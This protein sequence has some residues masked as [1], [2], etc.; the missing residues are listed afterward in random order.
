MFISLLVFILTL[1]VLFFSSRSLI[2]QLT[3]FFNRLFKSS[4]TTIN[5]IFFLLLP[6]IF[7]H[8]FS[9]VLMATLLRVQTGHISL[10]PRFKTPRASSE[11]S[12]LQLGSAQI[13]ACDPIRLTLIG[14][15]PFITGTIVLW[16]ILSLGLN[17]NLN[18]F[19]LLPLTQLPAYLLFLFSYLIFAITNTM[20][21]SPS[22]LQAAA[23]PII[24]LLIIS[25]IF[26][27]TNLDLPQII[28]TYSSSL[29]SLL[30]TI[31]LAV[32]I[33]NLLILIPIKLINKNLSRPSKADM[34]H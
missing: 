3:Y 12:R 30:S 31:F 26:Q 34:L 18:Q 23:F 2:N 32:F 27:L 17:L 13:G 14:T 9:H 25:G 28:L 16:A 7:L 15:A 24:L 6:G 20:F 1:I 10:R 21:S 22:D 33:L 29:F 5:L 8:E 4:N 11:P 19:S